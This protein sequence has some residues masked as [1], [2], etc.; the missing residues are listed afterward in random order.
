MKVVCVKE[1]KFGFSGIH[2]EMVSLGEKEYSASRAKELIATGWAKPISEKAPKE[3]EHPAEDDI[4]AIK[5]KRGWW[6]VTINGVTV[7]VRA[8]TE[9]KAIEG[10]REKINA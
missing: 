8:K 10:A 1:G 6:D 4:E 9:V 7:N 2:V 3:P 5:G